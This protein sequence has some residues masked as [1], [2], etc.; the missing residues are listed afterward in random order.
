MSFLSFFVLFPPS[1]RTK[2][3]SCWF[4]PVFIQTFPMFFSMRKL[5]NSLFA[6]T[7]SQTK[8]R[9]LSLFLIERNVLWNYIYKVGGVDLLGHSSLCFCF[10]ASLVS[11]LSRRRIHPSIWCLCVSSLCTFLPFGHKVFSFVKS[12]VKR[13][14]IRKPKLD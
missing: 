14:E 8:R 11:S 13:A 1:T 10:K 3:A 4:L 6:T 9:K 5:C 7:T 12:H 2:K